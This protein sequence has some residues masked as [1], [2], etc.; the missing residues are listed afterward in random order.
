MPLTGIDRPGYGALVNL[1]NQS[2]KVF[3]FRPQDTILLPVQGQ[4]RLVILFAEIAAL[5]VIS[6]GN[7]ATRVFTN[8]IQRVTRAAEE[9]SR[10]NFKA[11]SIVRSR[12]EI[13]SL[14]ATLNDMS[15]KMDAILQD[16][17]NRVNE[18]TR[19]IKVSAEIGR[20]LSSV[21]KTDDLVKEVVNQIK[22]A[23]NYYHVQ[24]YLMD[25][26]RQN[27]VLVSG[28]GSVGQQMVSQGHSIPLGRGLVGRAAIRGA[29]V[30]ISNTSMETNW[31]SNP[32][33][34]ETR[35]ELAVPLLFGE[36]VL[37]VL[38]VQQDQ[39]NGLDERDADTLQVIAGQ[40]AIAI[41]NSRLLEELQQRADQQTQLTQIMDEITRTMNIEKALKVA[42]R[43][44]GRATG[45]P[46]IS[47]RY[48]NRITGNN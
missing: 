32:L 21:L 4:T 35:S 19:S 26:G 25:S 30:L 14:A 31:L 41:R 9:Y 48:K 27:L 7:L 15:G 45:G 28:T 36:Q 42:V 16:L 12:D 5:V 29:Y 3:Y 47:I 43:E 24:I 34:P 13:G 20:Q 1:N 8:P 46:S 10:G 11:K 40:V 2:W 37:G 23:F 38:D 17:D 33:L 44:V 6:L 39:A 22:A 18:R